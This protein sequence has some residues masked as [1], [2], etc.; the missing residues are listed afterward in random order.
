M[1]KCENW[2]ARAVIVLHSKTNLLLPKHILWFHANKLLKDFQ[3]TTWRSVHMALSLKHS[4]MVCH[5]CHTTVTYFSGSDM[6][7]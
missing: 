7:A 2:L 6:L 5:A 3:V 1:E 4:R